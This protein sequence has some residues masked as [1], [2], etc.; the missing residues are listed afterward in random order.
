M[1]LTKV[2][3]RELTP[4]ER[5]ALEQLASSRTAQARFV[6]RA[7]ILLDLAGGRR[8]SQAARDLGVSR[9][10]VYTWIHRFNDQGLR[11]LEDRPRSGRPHTYTAEQRA[12][13]LAAALSD[14]K[15]LGLPFGCWTLDRLQAYLNEHKGIPIK[16]SRIDEI[17]TAEGLRWRKQETWF[18]ERVDPAF[19]EKR[20]SSSGST[21]RRRR[22]R[23]WSASTR[24]AR[25][26]PRA[27]RG[28]G[29]SAPSPS[30]VP[31]AKPDRPNEPARRS[32][33]GGAAKGT[34]SAPSA[35]RPVKP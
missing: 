12:E 8:P 19:A 18:G 11:G 1:T 30:R 13:V 10:T 21:R 35:P 9:P 33:P 14:P 27:S 16:R 3:L 5:H 31:K 22:A 29:S 4:E 15:D 25:S 2:T 34:S 6:E 23:S 17:L 24:W 28:S 7:R 26:R 32:T 20:G